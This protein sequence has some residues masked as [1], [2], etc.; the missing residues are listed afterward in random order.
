MSRFKQRCAL[1]IAILATVF[2]VTGLAASSANATSFTCTQTKNAYT[3]PYACGG[4]QFQQFTHGVLDMSADGNFWN[5]SVRATTENQSGPAAPNQDWTVFA[6]D[7]LITGGEGD[8]GQYVAMFTPNGVIPGGCD[9][10][11]QHHQT[12]GGL[13]TPQTVSNS[14]IDYC[15]S[16]ENVPTVVRGH[17]TFRWFG[18]LRNCFLGDFRDEGSP[19]FTLA[20]A[21]SD[22]VHVNTVTN[23]NHY[24]VWAPVLGAQ[25]ESLVNE[26]LLHPE[27]RHWVGG[28]SRYV[29]DIQAGGP[30]GSRLLAYP[31][32]GGLNQVVKVI[33]CQP[34]VTLIS[35]LAQ[36]C[37]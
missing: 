32:N 13:N 30:S 15:L 36:V 20:V 18:V 3:T 31:Y 27:F 2:T 6:E 10:G 26:A 34:P 25:D 12:C 14:P 7:G 37:S 29:L 11:L 1:F 24:M 17:H 22:G 33:G 9:V 23:P 16:V 21:P 28:N 8:L 35:G 19:T 5:A 4:L